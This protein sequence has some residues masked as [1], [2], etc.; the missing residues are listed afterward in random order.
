MPENEIVSGELE[1]L[2]VIVTF[3]CALP[4]AAGAKITFMVTDVLGLRM[5]PVE[6][7]LTVKPAPEIE[8][9]DPPVFVTVTGCVLLLLTFTFPKLRLEVLE[10]S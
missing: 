8:T 4:E 2:L 9:L 3:P 1:A 6:M 5:S 7:P 10:L